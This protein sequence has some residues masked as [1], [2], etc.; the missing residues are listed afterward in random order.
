V[1]LTSRRPATDAGAAER[2]SNAGSARTGPGALRLAR[3]AARRDEPALQAGAATLGA[4]LRDP[5]ASSS[6]PRTA[7]HATACAHRRPLAALLRDSRVPLWTDSL[8][9][10]C[11]GSPAL[12]DEVV[13]L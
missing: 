3:V 7:R 12:A 11:Q 2:S 8:T 13:A 5:A 6:C 4:R 1:S 10:K 9:W